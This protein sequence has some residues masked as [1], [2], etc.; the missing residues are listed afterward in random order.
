MGA[1]R[2]VAGLIRDRPANGEDRICA[3][4]RSPERSH[5]ELSQHACR[6][7]RECTHSG[8]NKA[9]HGH[10]VYPRGLSTAYQ[11]RRR[12]NSAAH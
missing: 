10:L 6:K 2:I 8:E 11:R 4:R 9:V 3:L 12:A 7:E 1:L 5:D